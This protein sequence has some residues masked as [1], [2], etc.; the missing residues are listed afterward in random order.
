MKTVRCLLG[1]HDWNT[2]N[3]NTGFSMRECK[4]CNRLENKPVGIIEFGDVTDPNRSLQY[5]IDHYS[6]FGIHPIIKSAQK[7]IEK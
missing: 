4:N 5:W 7:E 1:F 2:V 6:E 3:F